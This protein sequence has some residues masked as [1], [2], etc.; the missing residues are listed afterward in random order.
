QKRSSSKAAQNS[1]SA[2]LRQRSPG[3]ENSAHVALLDVAHAF[4]PRV[5]DTSNDTVLLDLAGLE[6]LHGS[7]RKMG[8]DLAER[9]TAVGIEANI[10]LAGNPDAAMPTARGFNGIT[11]IPLGKESQH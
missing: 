5:E 10:A 2:I 8:S 7:G 4:T 9:I 11:I 6:R 3:Q 1:V